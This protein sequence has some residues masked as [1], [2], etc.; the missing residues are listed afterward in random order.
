[1]FITDSILSVL[2]KFLMILFLSILLWSNLF[3]GIF[4]LEWFIYSQTLAYIVTAIVAVSIT[5]G[6]ANYFKPRLDKRYLILIIKKSAPFTL[7]IFLMA[8]YNRIEPILLE[9]LLPDGEIQS[10]IYAQGFRIME[11]MSNFSLLFPVLL[12]PIFSKMLKN[13]ENISELVS[14]ASNLLLVPAIVVAFSCFA[15]SNDLM[16]FLYHQP[17]SG[18]IFRMLILGFIGLSLTYIY[19]TLLTANGSFR[20]LNIMAALAVIC[21]VTLNLY[22]IPHFKA[23]GAAWSS[24]LTQTGTGVIQMIMAYKILNIASIKSRMIKFAL[25]IAAF[26]A[27]LIFFKSCFTNWILGLSSAIFCGF[28]IAL[29][30]KVINIKEMLGILNESKVITNPE[31]R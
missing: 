12:L 25:W 27:I 17:Q 2:D 9:R 5:L 16:N 11:V 24:F 31:S 7:L 29:T 8:I 28:L 26:I 23:Q 1:M 13:K 4:K 3:N 10:G 15:Y 30:L 20:E 22:L 6:K 18:P 14:F 19:G 21:N